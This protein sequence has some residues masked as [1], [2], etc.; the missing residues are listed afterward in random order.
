VEV[1]GDVLV[2]RGTWPGAGGPV[3]YVEVWDR[4]ARGPAAAWTA[5]GVPGLAVVVGSRAAVLVDGRAVGRPCGAALAASDAAGRWRISAAL[6]DPT[7]GWDLE[8]V[9]A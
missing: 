4:L 6:V 1:H 9:R 3:P 8:W 2:E 7:A 5:L